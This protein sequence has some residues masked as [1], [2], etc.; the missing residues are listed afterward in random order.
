MELYKKEEL[1]VY[2]FIFILYI[3]FLNIKNFPAPSG[4]LFKSFTTDLIFIFST[5]YLKS[6]ARLFLPKAIFHCVMKFNYDFFQLLNLTQ[7]I[8]SSITFQTQASPIA[9]ELANYK[10]VFKGMF[11]LYQKH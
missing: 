5:V 9:L 3:K 1:P 4:E 8:F 2:D 7:N 6:K 11:K 10:S